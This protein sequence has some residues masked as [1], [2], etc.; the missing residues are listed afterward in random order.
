M[1]PNLRA[2]LPLLSDMIS[3]MYDDSHPGIMKTP[4]GVER[5]RS[6]EYR[7]RRY[8]LSRA[9]G[10]RRHKLVPLRDDPPWAVVVEYDVLTAIRTGVELLDA[11]IDFGADDFYRDMIL[12]KLVP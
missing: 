2:A 8:F 10:M 6:F 3:E 7:G 4:D 5:G 12:L 11:E 1:Q 9:K